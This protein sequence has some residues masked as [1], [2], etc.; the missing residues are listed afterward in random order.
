MQAMDKTEMRLDPLTDAWTIFSEAR[1]I[2]PSF[3]S[4]IRESETASPFLAGNER[5]ASPALHTAPA[6][7]EGWQVRVVPN[8][9]P[10]VRVEG[11][12]GRHAD[13]FYD[14]MDGVGAHEIVIEDPGHAAL[15]ELPLSDVEKVITAWKVRM[16]DLMKDPRMRSFS[17]VKNVG[18]P[19]GARVSHSISQLVAMAIVPPLLLRKLRIAREFYERKKRAIFEDILAEEVRTGSRLVY[20]NNGFAA[21]CPY[22]SR[23]PFEM[24]VYPKRQCADFHGI[25]DQ[26]T[27]Q[28]ADVIKTVLRKL[29]RALAHPPYNLMLFT[30]PARTPRTD[31]WTTIERDFRWHIEILPRL[32]FRGGVELATGCWLNSVW[33][34]TA[35]HHLRSTELPE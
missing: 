23:A 35:A 11:E 14:R 26:E 29:N 19:A 17:V 20:E 33:P 1:T 16:L 31:H 13:G 21:F 22:A 27:A 6:A 25:T 32:Y 10:V 3:G 18:Q 24:A 12:T 2:P 30:A 7:R 5:F 34:E 9:A 4:V 15:E 8:R 28:L